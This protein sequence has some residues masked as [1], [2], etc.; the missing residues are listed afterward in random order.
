MQL[1]NKKRPLFRQNNHANK[2]KANVATLADIS[3]LVLV[4]L[5]KKYFFSTIAHF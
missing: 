1:I 4:T 5:R 2:F 3:F